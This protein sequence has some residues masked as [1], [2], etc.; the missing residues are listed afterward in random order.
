VKTFFSDTN[1][2]FECR[3]A[4]DLPWHELDESAPGAGPD[5]LLI[6]PPTVITEI[7][8][9]KAKGN[10]RTAK[11]ARDVSARLREAIL[12]A[13]HHAVL[14]DA[15]PKIVLQLPPV[16]K[17]D[18]ARY[19]DLDRERPDHRIVAECATSLIWATQQSCSRYSHHSACRSCGC[20]APHRAMRNRN[21]PT[22]DLKAEIIQAI[23]FAPARGL[24]LLRDWLSPEQ[25]VQFERKGYFDDTGCHSGRRY[26]IQHAIF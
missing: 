2:F 7:E 4:I 20:R 12:A 11:R 19:P 10:S 1:F 25:L 16:F 14:R 17:V 15:N 22:P 13:D 9:H 5:I 24:E 26:R 8:R 6:V 23:D 18:F 21:C 3:K